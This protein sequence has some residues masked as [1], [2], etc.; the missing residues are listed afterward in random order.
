MSIRHVHVTIC[1][2][3]GWGFAIVKC[4]KFNSIL[5]IFFPLRLR[6]PLVLVRGTIRRTRCVGGVAGNLITFKRKDAPA[7]AIHQKERGD[8]SRQG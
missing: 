3:T 4:V 2:G 6:V 8:V 7:V 5:F 1:I